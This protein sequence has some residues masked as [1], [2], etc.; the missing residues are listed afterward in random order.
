MFPSSMHIIKNGPT[1]TEGPP[2]KTPSGPR[3]PADHQ[4]TRLVPEAL[5]HP[6]AHT[7]KQPITFGFSFALTKQNL[8]REMLPDLW[9]ARGEI[10]WGTA[11]DGGVGMWINRLAGHLTDGIYGRSRRQRIN[12]FEGNTPQP[13]SFVLAGNLALSSSPGAQLTSDSCNVGSRE[14]LGWEQHCVIG[15][16]VCGSGERWGGV[17][18]CF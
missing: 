6:L 17:A 12:F 16:D 14:R 18:V 5:R 9:L 8:C 15:I 3:W 7:T 2:I 11:A 10:R 1:A 13:G 4:T